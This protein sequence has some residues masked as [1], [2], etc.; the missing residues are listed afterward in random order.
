MSGGLG[1]SSM[2]SDPKRSLQRS[3]YTKT[4]NQ[5]KGVQQNIPQTSLS[6]VGRPSSV[7]RIGL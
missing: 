4:K 5:V 7:R 1:A 6:L 2:T 3:E